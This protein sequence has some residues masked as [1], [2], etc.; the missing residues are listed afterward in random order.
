MPFF[1]VSGYITV[2]SSLHVTLSV[3]PKDLGIDGPVIS[4]SSIAD[5]FPSLLALTASI[6]VTSDLP[7]PPLPLTTAITFLTLPLL[8]FLN[9]CGPFLDSQSELQLE[10]LPEQFS[11]ITSSHY[12]F[13]YFCSNSSTGIGF[14]K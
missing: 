9:I 10:Q 8:A 1:E 2:P 12:S 5:F 14:E 7:T 6:D 11:L 4:A 3:S 13:M